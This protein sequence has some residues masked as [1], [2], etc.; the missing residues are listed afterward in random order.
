MRRL[1][2]IG[3]DG[4]P[5]VLPG[6][7]LAGMILQAAAAV[8]GLRAGD[9]VVLAQKV[10]SKAEDRYVV[11]DDVVPSARA[12]RIAAQCDKDPRQV[13][14]VLSEASEVVRHRP[15][16]LIVRHHLGH[17]LANAGIDASNVPR[18]GQGRERILLLPKDPDGSA[19]SLRRALVA[20][21]GVDLAVVI[22]D[23][24]GRAWRV[25]SAGIAIGVAGLPAVQ[26]L[27]GQPDRDGRELQASEL[28]IADEVSAA[29]SI[30]MGQGA[31]GV[32]V[33]LVRGMTFDGPRGT[34]H[35]LVRQPGM[36]LFR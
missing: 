3:L 12:V 21:S 13:E 4:L 15:G 5:E 10:I 2:L 20:A 8:G 1:E 27:R 16:V 18:D 7:D 19:A 30:V 31:E 11:L 6:A 35:D 28:G 25:G 32:P 33:V 17:V 14:V 34:A 29:A 24:P 23:S 9:V 22:N 36:D 26:D